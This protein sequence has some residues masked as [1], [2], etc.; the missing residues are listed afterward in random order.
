MSDPVEPSSVDFQRHSHLAGD[1]PSSFTVSG[2]AALWIEGTGER[3][4]LA[5]LAPTEEPLLQCFDGI[6]EG[7][8]SNL[9]ILRGPTT[10]ANSAALRAALPWL[11]PA[12]LGLAT[13]A[14]FGD[15]LG[16]ATPGHVRALQRVSAGGSAFI[17]PIFAQQSIREMDRTGRTPGEVLD[18]A[19]WGAFQAGWQG[20]LGADADHLKTVDDV[21]VAA[22]AGYSFYT[23]DPSAHVDDRAGQASR[24]TVEGKLDALP[25]QE[26]E[27][28]LLDLRRRHAGT[29]T[30]LEDRTIVVTEEALVRAAAK[31]GRAIAHV[32]RLYRR[33]LGTGVPFEMEISV[34]ETETP[35]SPSE[36]LYITGEL[37]RLG[38]RW[39]SFAPRFVGAFEKGIEY[40][41]DIDELGKD[42]AVHA[43][44]ARA[45]GPYKLSLHSGSDKFNVYPLL[46]SATRGL[47][48]L[49]TAGTSYLEALRVVATIDPV[50]FRA[51]V[52]CARLHYSGDRASYHVS[53]ELQRLQDAGLVRDA[54][55]PD[56]LDDDDA[57]QI[58]HVTF[59]SVLARFLAPLLELLRG[60]EQLY[61]DTLER[62]FVRHLA[63][64]A[65]PVRAPGGKA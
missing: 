23:I 4:T 49:K 43:A 5:L 40:V 51:I 52:E 7:F 24:S 22:A 15:R 64:F 37:H 48:H 1:Y 28:D 17:A 53:A 38:V 25:W 56:L 42:L 2:N 30:E 59:G 10:A 11:K 8:D 9:V 13:S 39:V 50:L 18:D 26:L 57:R 63:P 36:H 27:S 47:A 33:L 20:P 3:K 65:Q 45:R 19:T 16:L 35:T 46:H 61:A 32:A 44:I 21:D 54:F 55:L 60:H 6:P 12:P 14:G 58:L 34:D 31:Y 41:G 29:A 62:H